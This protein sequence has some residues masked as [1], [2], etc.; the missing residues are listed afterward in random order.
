MN[1]TSDPLHFS[2]TLLQLCVVHAK[3]CHKI[4]ATVYQRRG[5][6]WGKD[7]TVHR[8]VAEIISLKLLSFGPIQQWSPTLGPQ[9]FLNYN[10]QKLSP[11]PLLVRISGSWFLEA[12]GWGPL[13]YRTTVGLLV[14]SSSC[15]FLKRTLLFMLFF[16]KLSFKIQNK[17]CNYIHSQVYKDPSESNDKLRDKCTKIVIAPNFSS[18]FKWEQRNDFITMWPSY[19]HL[20]RSNSSMWIAH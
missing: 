9:M 2:L 1:S 16:K 19:S 12:Q 5:S 7:R 20:L 6:D 3:L 15:S 18:L 11:S 14:S 4:S 10:S 17:S 13:P 8:T